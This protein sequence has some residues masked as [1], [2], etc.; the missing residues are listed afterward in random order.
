MF[1]ILFAFTP[2]LLFV[3][4]ASASD[5]AV[6]LNQHR[7]LTGDV[8]PGDAPGFP[9]TISLPGSYQLSGNLE[10]PLGAAGI[11]ITADHV[12]LN[13][14]GFSIIG[15]RHEPPTTTAE[16]GVVVGIKVTSRSDVTILNG[17]VT[18]AGDGIRFEAIRNGRVER[19][20]VLANSGTGIVL[21][22]NGVIENSTVAQNDSGL[23]LDN[24]PVEATPGLS[25]IRNTEI[26][27]NRETG[28]SLQCPNT[29]LI[30]DTIAVNGKDVILNG[31]GC[32]VF[33][34]LISSILEEH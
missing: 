32:T 2:L 27:Q 33:N 8:T 6:L 31:R 29:N 15:N 13:L 17:T 23:V 30:G 18:F 34:T 25:S 26:L 16:A 1:R 19:L 14:N 4:V 3:P 11:E 12:T 22:G 9:I 24:S 7:A 28:I 20:R 5:G 10:L 21:N